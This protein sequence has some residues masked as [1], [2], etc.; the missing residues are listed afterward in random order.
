MQRWLAAIMQ[1]AIRDL[2]LAFEIAACGQLVKGYADTH[3]RAVRNF[4][5]IAENYF[6]SS[7]DPALLAFKI[8]AARKTAL[9]DPEG[10]S[11]MLEIAKS[12]GNPSTVNRRLAA[13]E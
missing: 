3:A 11:L 10:E 1:A 2:A 6:D 12:P 13:A 8:Q 4:D 5:L 9:A 7:A